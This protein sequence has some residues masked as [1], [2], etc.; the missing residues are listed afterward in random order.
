MGRLAQVKKDKAD[1]RIN[2]G[3][4]PDGLLSR[5][6]IARELGIS[7]QR[8]CQCEQ[9]ALAK[10]RVAFLRQGFTEADAG[11]ALERLGCRRPPEALPLT[12]KDIADMQA[13]AD[14]VLLNA[15]RE[16]RRTRPR[17]VGRMARQDDQG[18]ILAIVEAVLRGG[19]SNKA[20]A[21]AVRSAGYG[22]NNN[23]LGRICDKARARLAAA[24]LGQPS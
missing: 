16:R 23:R 13:A 20:C 5:I 6:D 18:R 10:M 7:P 1:R 4:R 24:V 22:I 15:R 14:R 12:F 19:G 11:W 17:P 8:V 2:T 21:R 9:E 3:R